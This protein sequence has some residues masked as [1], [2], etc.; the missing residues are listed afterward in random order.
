MRTLTIAVS[1][2]VASMLVAACGGGSNQREP[3]TPKASEQADALQACQAAKDPLNPMIVEWPSTGRSD[4]D[5]ASRRGIVIVSYSGC[6]VKVL[7]NCTA[8]GSYE[9]TPST[10]VGDTLRFDDESKLYAELPLGAASLKGELAQG[11]TLELSYVAVGQ[12]ASSSS[13]AAL[14]G[15]CGGATHW[16]KSMTVGAYALDTMASTKVGAGANGTNASAGGEAA[17]KRSRRSG[18]GDVEGCRSGSGS[19]E[20]CNAILRL[21]LAELAPASGATEAKLAAGRCGSGRCSVLDPGT[22]GDEDDGSGLVRDTRTGL[23]WMRKPYK[24]SGLSQEGSS[25]YCRS[26]G[27]RLSTKDEALGIAAGNKELCAFPSPWW[28]W[29]WPPPGAE[30]A[31]L[32]SFRGYTDEV[33][34]GV[35]VGDY[36]SVLCVR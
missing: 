1:V 17:A 29:T 14:S 20:S 32:V 5:T 18:A 24:G 35:A 3:E 21:G 33:E 13:P 8:E 36:G 10:P 15:D 28:T 30:R 27:M 25:V 4:L 9:L 11:K 19:G 23:T 2:M 7:S 26:K 22:A 12:R 34:V 31:W 16:V 6:V